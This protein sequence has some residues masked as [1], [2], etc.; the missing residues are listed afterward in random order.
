MMP[1]RSG[2][3]CSGFAGRVEKCFFCERCYLLKLKLPPP[4]AVAGSSRAPH[5]LPLISTDLRLSS[6]TGVLMLGVEREAL[7]V[8]RSRQGGGTLDLLRRGMFEDAALC[9][10]QVRCLLNE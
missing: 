9:R 1:H 3:C 2:T 5:Y 6:A 10:Q 7:A 4:Q 8:S